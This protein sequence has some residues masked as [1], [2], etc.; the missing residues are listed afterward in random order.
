MDFAITYPRIVP[1]DAK[2]AFTTRR[3]VRDDAAGLRANVSDARAGDLVLGQVLKIGQHKSIQLT[4]GRASQLYFDDYVVLACG[5]RYAPDQFEAVAE[6]DPESSDL[7]AAGGLIGRMRHAH[8]KMGAPTQIKPLGLLVDDA[9]EVINLNAYRL[10]KANVLPQVLVIGVVGASMNAGKTTA[11]ASLAHG[12]SRAGFPVAALK[13]TGTGAFGDYNAFLDAGVRYVADF[14]DVGMASTYRQPIERIEEGFAS[15]L[16]DAAANGARIAVV[17]LAD[18]VFQEETARLLRRSKVRDALNGLVL[19]V[20]DALGAVGGMKILR[21]MRLEPIAVSGMVTCSPL[22]VAEAQALIPVP[23]AS[24]DELRN[25]LYAS[26][27]VGEMLSASTGVTAPT[28]D[29]RDLARAA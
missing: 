9:N 18:G 16:A 22:A 28:P 5:D 12:L 6:L 25:S 4:H 24:C 23:F 14:T 11:A 13:A 27:L 29:R 26:N 15:L 2:W 1:A 8:M 21:E 17:E 19:A 7:V 20:P 10:P 3:V